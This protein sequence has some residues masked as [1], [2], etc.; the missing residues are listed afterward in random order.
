MHVNK[1]FF[2]FFF[3]LLKLNF[4]QIIL[5]FVLIKK[6]IIS[7]IIYI[8]KTLGNGSLKE[9]FAIFGKG[10]FTNDAAKIAEF[11]KF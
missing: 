1:S 2:S 3:H 11:A 9:V 8:Y 6:K 4:F 5:Y 10:A 7:K